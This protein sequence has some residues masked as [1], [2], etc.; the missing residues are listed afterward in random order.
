M[1]NEA[2]KHR[3]IS[4]IQEHQAKIAEL[5]EQKDQE[6]VKLNTIPANSQCINNDVKSFDSTPLGRKQKLYNCYNTDYYRRLKIAETLL[7]DAIYN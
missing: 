4:S 1:R 2:V 5:M 3:D 6:I 7:N